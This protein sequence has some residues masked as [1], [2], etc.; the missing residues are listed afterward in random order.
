MNLISVPVAVYNGL[1]EWQLD[2]F[3]HRHKELYGKNAFQKA[4]AIV[5]RR[6]SL[7]EKR[8]DEFKWNNDVPH[9][10]CESFADYD[11]DL[12]N[13][14][15]ASLKKSQNVEV[16]IATSLGS[17]QLWQKLDYDFLTSVPHHEMPK[18]IKSHDIGISV[19]KNDLGVCLKS[20]AST[21][22][23]EFLACGKPVII[24]S[25]QGDFGVLIEK[26]RAGIVT[27]GSSD[28]EIES[29]ARRLIE[30]I[31]DSSTFERCR[32][33]VL[34]YYDLNQGVAEL[35]RIYEQV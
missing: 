27:F 3:W 18:L 14:L 11:I 16:T 32:N 26:H 7:T 21:K 35:I 29:Y 10:L 22:T 4:K 20:V 34:E 12:I 9:S 8:C 19:W 28:A 25:N 6:N 1:F 15:I 33:L 5:I 13:K 30:L 17:T 2:L 23:A 31:D 24:N